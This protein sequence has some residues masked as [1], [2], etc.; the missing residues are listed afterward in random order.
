MGPGGRS[1][2]SRRGCTGWSC[3]NNASAR[4]AASAQ[5]QAQASGA[6]L[7]AGGGCDGRPDDAAAGWSAATTGGER[8]RTRWTGVVGHGRDSC[9]GGRQATAGWRA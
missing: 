3:R 4:G 7:L 8:H 6:A 1:G 5:R 2:D 9:G